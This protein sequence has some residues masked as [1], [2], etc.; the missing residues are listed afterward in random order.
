MENRDK[1]GNVLNNLIEKSARSSF[2]LWL[3][4]RILWWKIPFNAPHSI[5]ITGIT[6]GGLVLTLPYKRKNKNHI[7]GMHACALATLCEYA[8]GLQLSRILGANNFRL[9]LH[10]IKMEYLWQAKMDVNV[11]FNFSE[12]EVKEEILKPLERGEKAVIK[13]LHVEV[14]NTSGEKI[15]NGFISWQIKSWKD[16]KT[17]L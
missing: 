13:M 11:N 8:T 14:I 1:V 5:K 9:I 3:L 10:E 16:V 17:N 7:N 2:Y 12:Q 4:N 15:A 6:G